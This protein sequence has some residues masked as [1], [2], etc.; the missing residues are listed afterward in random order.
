MFYGQGESIVLQRDVEAVRVPD[1]EPVKLHKDEIVTIYQALGGSYTVLTED[2]TMARISAGDA[3]AL[4]KEPPLIPDLKEG[5]DP[6]T[7]KHNVWQVL[8]TI[9]DPEIPVNIVD[10][11][12][13][14]H[15]RVTPI[16]EGKNRVEIVMTLTAPG[17][18]MGPVIQQD[19][20]MAVKN[21]P[22]VEEVQV[23]VVFDPPWSRDMMTE[24]AKLQLGMI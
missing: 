3:D 24:A 22:G 17:C 6:E 18:G 16:E 9:Y 5:T 14:Y 12:L 7:V 20:E 13:V 2:G 11:G 10:L 8:K 19:V 21:L 15:V 4:G 1:G 23:E